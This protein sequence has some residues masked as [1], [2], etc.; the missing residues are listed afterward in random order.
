MSLEKTTGMSSGLIM[1]LFAENWSQTFIPKSL[2]NLQIIGERRIGSDVR[3][4]FLI[5]V[6]K[7]FTNVPESN[8]TVLE[9]PDSTENI[10][11]ECDTLTN[12]QSVLSNSNQGFSSTG[13]EESFAEGGR[14]LGKARA[15]VDCTPSP[16]DKD[17]LAFK[18]GDIIDIL[19]KSSSGYWVGKLGNQIGHFKFI[20][21]EEIPNG[22]RK[23]SKRRFSSFDNKSN[24]GKTL[25]DLLEHLGLEIYMNVLVLNGYHNLD[26]LKG[27][28][29]QDLI[30][31]GIVN[32]DH[33]IKLLN[34]IE[35]FEEVT[36][37][38]RF[39]DHQEMALQKTR[40]AKA[41]ARQIAAAFQ[42]PSHLKT[43]SI[44]KGF[45]VGFTFPH[46]FFLFCFLTLGFADPP[47]RDWGRIPPRGFKKD[48]FESRRGLW[49]GERGSSSAEAGKT[50][51]TKRF[52]GRFLLRASGRSQLQQSFRLVDFP[53][54]TNLREIV[55]LQW[56]YRTLSHSWAERQRLDSLWN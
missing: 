21:V 18:K 29:E 47:P 2:Q 45:F 24:L 43:N 4:V 36:K 8:T 32:S 26:S 14:T 33:R 25:E 3:L 5:S 10:S 48:I 54:S 31:L 15:L 27:I 34:A 19:A 16:Y 39:L 52:S 41:Q 9:A 40:K 12:Q 53:R 55:S 22:D 37:E 35:Y 6:P 1:A 17:G 13:E 50:C 42:M 23:T 51:G 46:D 38:I 44:K 11:K 7:D 30:S 28:E 49:A 56:L 20:N